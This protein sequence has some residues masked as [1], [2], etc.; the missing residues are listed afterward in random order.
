MPRAARARP[1]VEVLEDRLVPAGLTGFSLVEQQAFPVPQ[2]T[3]V[4]SL[5][6]VF[7]DQFN[8]NWQGLRNGTMT[9]NGQTLQQMVTADIQQAAQKQGYTAY[10]ISES[11][12]SLGTY[13]A[14]LDTSSNAVQI[15]YDTWDTMDFTT[16]TKTI[17]GS[18][19]DPTFHVIY[20]LTIYVNLTLP[21]ALSSQAQVTSSAA[22]LAH[23]VTVSS[24]NVGVWLAN[25]FGNNIIQDLAN[26]I[27]GNSKDL[28]GLVPTGQLNSL[29]QFEAAKGF[30]HLHTGLD[31]S[32]NLLLTA[33]G[34]NLVINGSPNDDI[35]LKKLS[36]NSVVVFAGGQWATF[37]PGSFTTITINCGT[38]SN[39]VN[40][41][42]VPAGVSVKVNEGSGSY[43]N[44]TVFVGGGSLANV[45]GPV[46]VNNSNA[47]GKMTLV[48]DDSLD[49]K[50]RTV[51]VTNNAVQ[52][53]G[54]PAVG[55]SGYV[56]YLSVYGGSGTNWFDVYSTSAP[57]L[58]V[59]GA[60]QNYVWIGNN[61]SLSG[62]G[63]AITVEGS[64]RGGQNSLTIDDHNDSG[65]N[66]TLTA[67]SISFTGVPTISYNGIASLDLV[68]ASGHNTIA[69]NGVPWGTAVTIWN[70]AHNTLTGPD[71]WWVTLYS[72]LP[73]WD[74]GIFGVGF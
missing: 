39:Q 73:V 25:L 20:E 53:S 31:G 58:L 2:A 40:I 63:A 4:I 10:D 11:F 6:T 29:L 32:G 45:A 22:S 27:N 49:P 35:I 54:L 55:Y 47:S 42:G 36:D 51:S 62:I 67:N 3:P 46:S 69:V 21:S 28:S 64:D 17:F 44:D 26:Q 70:G 24:Q 68:G 66:V 33:Q 56:T 37:D 43:D 52:F 19:G 57:L 14:K 41:L 7:K 13:S 74:L 15:Q 48:V 23:N 71:A 61:D 5:P 8:Q 59:P 16:T 18:Y 65:R 1:Q 38:G 34:P 60:G 12:A 30:T 50:G 9:I 72:G